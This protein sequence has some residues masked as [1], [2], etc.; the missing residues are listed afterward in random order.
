VL[1]MIGKGHFDE[2]LVG[3]VAFVSLVEGFD[4]F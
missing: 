1:E 2:R 4:E 3:Y